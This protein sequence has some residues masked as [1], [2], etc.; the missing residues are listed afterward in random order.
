MKEIILFTKSL[1]SSNHVTVLKAF[2]F[3]E[4]PDLRKT[5]QKQG[6]RFIE[7]PDLRKETKK[8]INT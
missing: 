6:I 1:Q 2:I 4:F 8:V 5:V 7:F 3:I